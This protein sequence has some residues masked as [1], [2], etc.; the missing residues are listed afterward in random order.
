MSTNPFNPF[1]PPKPPDK[2]DPE[3]LDQSLAELADAAQT[4]RDC[5]LMGDDQEGRKAFTRAITALS[6]GV[7]QISLLN[8]K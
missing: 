7:H 8:R 4:A 2:Y 1:P 5:F 3:V 6:Q